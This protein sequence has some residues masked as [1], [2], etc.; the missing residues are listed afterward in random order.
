MPLHLSSEERLL[1][2]CAR[3]NLRTKDG[4]VLDDLLSE[5]LNWQDVLDKARWHRLSG[6]LYH[7]LRGEEY[8]PR[9]PAQVLGQL[10]T[11]YYFNVARYLCQRTELA[12]VLKATAANSIPIM[13]LKGAALHETV[14]P[15]PGMRPQNDI[16]LLARPQ[17]AQ[18]LYQSILDLGYGCRGTQETQDRTV[19]DHRHLPLLESPDKPVWFEVHHHIT[20]EDSALHF[21][22]SDFWDEAY[23]LDSFGGKTLVPSPEHMLIHLCV[24]FLLDRQ[25]RSVAALGQLCDIAET[26]K[27]YKEGVDWLRFMSQTRGY[28]I[29][30][31][32]FY[33][34]LAAH[35]L[36]EA[37][38]PQQVLSELKPATFDAD[39]LDLFMR[40][41]VLNTSE[42]LAHGLAS[43]QEDYGLGALSRTVLR[44][45]MPDRITLAEQFGLNPRSRRIYLYY[46]ARWW[47]TMLAIVRAVTGPTKLNTDIALDKWMH[48]VF[49]AC[50]NGS[51]SPR[52]EL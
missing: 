22:I 15:N 30:A 48:S 19:S 27:Y 13:L 50:G 10:K 3:V 32:V 31:A 34:L 12:N 24:H 44:R 4:N 28:G 8:S 25:Y 35:R 39:A 47:R 38:V 36:L 2:A 16:D 29:G 18:A 51:S 11:T 23:P 9:V 1:L 5:G 42:F 17:D 7:H 26:A 6:L 52:K 46:P 41:R 20:R 33:V 43:T 37:E 49:M 45:L 21:D 14:Y 40:H